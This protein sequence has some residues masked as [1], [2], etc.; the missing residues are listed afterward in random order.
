MRAHII[1]DGK[2][3]NTIEVESIDFMPGLISAENGGEIGWSWDGDSFYA[4]IVTGPTFE[5]LKIELTENINNLFKIETAAIKNG[6]MQEEIDTFNTQEKEAI[7]YKLDNDAKVP[8]IT[9]LAS[10][11]GITVDE[12]ADRILAHAAAYKDAIAKVM[13]KK[14]AF[15]DLLKS[16]TTIED[17]KN[18][19][20]K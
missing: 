18:I 16:A 17:L 20:V 13:G 5:E 4:P 3:S 7:A 11:R 15:E 12:L 14:H 8:L 10:V 2:I 9:G 1:T 6:V 19:E